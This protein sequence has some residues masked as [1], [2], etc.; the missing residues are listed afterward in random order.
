MK[1]ERTLSYSRSQKLTE[2]DLQCVSAA[3]ATIHGTVEVTYKSGS[4]WDS[5]A[6][7]TSD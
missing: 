2:A 5:V 6:D 7:A 4:G 3:G 1:N